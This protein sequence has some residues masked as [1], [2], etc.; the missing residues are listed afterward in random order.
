MP[1]LTRDLSPETY[2]LNPHTSSGIAETRLTK[3]FLDYQGLRTGRLRTSSSSEDMRVR[4]D[5]RRRAERKSLAH[6]DAEAGPLVDTGEN[7]A[8]MNRVTG[9][10]Q[11]RRNCSSLSAVSDCD[12]GSGASLI[13]PAGKR[14][15]DCICL[16]R[17][18]A[19][20]QTR[21]GVRLLR[22]ERLARTRVC[23]GRTCP[24]RR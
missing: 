24:V 6:L 16:S 4:R 8:A 10:R 13:V 18:R 17:H 7:R 21:W 2:V 14:R 20:V 5:E 9:L 19:Q 3:R 12:L 15:V 11:G 1:R 23:Y 22:E